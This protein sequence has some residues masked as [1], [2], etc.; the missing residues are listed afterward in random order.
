MTTEN[1]EVTQEI[2]ME[3]FTEEQ[4]QQLP[5]EARLNIVALEAELP[6]KELQVLNPLV[7]KIFAF[8]TEAENLKYIEPTDDNKEQVAENIEAF[9]SLKKKATEMKTAAADAKKA[10]KG[11]L[12]EMGKKVLAIEKSFG[13]LI[14]GCLNTV[15]TDFKPYTDAVKEKADAAT[16][17]RN[18]KATA[19][20]NQLTEENQQQAAAFDK[21][22]LIT[23]LKYEMLEPTEKEVAHAIE[24]FKLD[25]LFELRDALA[26]RTFES[27][28]TG[29][30]MT[31]MDDPV[32][33]SDIQMSFKH[34][35][36]GLVTNLNTKIS[37][38]QLE[39]TN[40]TLSADGPKSNQIGT[41]DVDG[42][43]GQTLR[44]AGD[45]PT[46]ET[47]PVQQP[48]MNNVP[49]DYFSE[50]LGVVTL[51]IEKIKKDLS[52][53]RAKF[54]KETRTEDQ[55]KEMKK[56]EGTIIL[57]EKVSK[58]QQGIPQQ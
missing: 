40:K 16:A 14:E 1:Q 12:D 26:F 4:L 49:R 37:A 10:I 39:E 33:L 28:S 18:A 35:I 57:L 55:A 44:F 41:V 53:Y 58:Y 9:K 24:N 15:L 19:T 5:E 8:K 30:D 50:C 21:S 34:K 42:A 11:P 17:K 46:S 54:P 43:T 2:V 6:A 25:K 47:Q 36:A 51:G 13:T 45:T 38:L 7:A 56:M 52:E 31:L 23:F 48:V 27:L 32:E 20:V 22:K 29:K 3:V